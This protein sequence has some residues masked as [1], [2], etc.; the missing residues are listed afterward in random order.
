MKTYSA[1]GLTIESEFELPE[2]PAVERDT[3]ASDITFGRGSVD[4]VPESVDGTDGRRIQAD[5]GRCRFT[6]DSYG[7][8]LVENGQRV[9]FE[10]SSP[11]VLEMKVIRRL[12]ENEMLGVL[13]HQRG[14]LVLHASAV[15]VEGRVAVFLGPRGVGKSTTA[16]AFHS[17]GYS[18][19][20]DDL[21]SIRLDGDTPIVDPGVPELRLHSDV[22]AA[23]NVEGATRC[24][25]DGGS[26]KLYYR[27]DTAP[28]SAPLDRC[29]LLERGEAVSLETLAQRPQLFSLIRSTYTRGLVPTTRRS[30]S[31]F[32]QCSTVVEEVPFRRLTRPRDIDSLWTLV[33]AVVKDQRRVKSEKSRS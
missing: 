24:S 23:L 28:D 7:S 9:L 33:D 4:P 32:D 8:F 14:R 3:A 12:L 10:P 1:Y 25:D 19:M 17:A 13:L 18:V 5:P 16:A 20:E 2:L 21:V 22:V 30:A 26:D 15:S 11:D 31:H 6:Y 27:M 29:Y